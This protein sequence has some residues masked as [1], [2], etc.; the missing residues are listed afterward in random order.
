[1]RPGDALALAGAAVFG[2]LRLDVTGGALDADT[3]PPDAKA[4]WTAVERGGA[5]VTGAFDAEQ[6]VRRKSAAAKKN[7]R[8]RS[9][10][11]PG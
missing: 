2:T 1:L 10:I 6:C 8:I 11:T 9:E 7:V 5:E 3:P 4:G